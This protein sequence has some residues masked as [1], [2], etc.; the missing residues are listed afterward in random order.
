L[1]C[2][3]CV[4]KRDLIHTTTVTLSKH[5]VPRPSF[6]YSEGSP[7][8]R[9]LCCIVC[10]VF[11]NRVCFHALFLCVICVISVLKA[12]QSLCCILLHVS[13]LSKTFRLW[14]TLISAILEGF[15]GLTRWNVIRM[16]IW[17]FIF[18]NLKYEKN[19]FEIWNV[20]FLTMLGDKTIEVH[21]YHY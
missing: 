2:L 15:I 21:G 1:Q 13:T 5:Y 6:L 4:Y 12:L 20:I 7:Y 17:S 3:Q 19:V 10:N 11:V 8:Q 14:L 18:M 16:K 9:V